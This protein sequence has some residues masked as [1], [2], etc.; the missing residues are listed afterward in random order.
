VAA[1]HHQVTDDNATGGASAG[2][3][4]GVIEQARGD[5]MAPIAALATTPFIMLAMKGSRV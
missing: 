1:L 2:A 5:P 4:S 3:L